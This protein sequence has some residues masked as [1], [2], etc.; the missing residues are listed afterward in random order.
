MNFPESEFHHRFE[1]L[2]QELERIN[3]DA[4]LITSEANFNYFTGYIAA[5]PWVS[6]SRNLL[7]ILPRQGQPVLVIPE[8]LSAEARHE[9]WIQQVYPST[10]VGEAPVATIASALRDLG[11]H[12]ARIG[13]E[14]GHEQRLGL[15][16][17]D[18][19]R[20]QSAIP[21]A[22][23]VDAS[24]AIW[25]LRMRKSAA[26]VDC[27]RESCRVTDS[28]F[29][30]L[31]PALRPGMTERDIARLMG[32]LL[33]E[34]GADRVGWIMMTSGRGQYHRTFGTP[35]D[36]VPQHGDMVWLDVSAIVN[37]YGA[38]YE[39]AGIIGGATSEQ[40][41]LQL[42][43]HEATMAGIDVIQPGLP[44]R[45]V[46]ETVSQRLERAGLQRLDAGRLGH[47][48]G[49]NSSEPPDVSLTDPTILAPGMVFTVEP[50]IVRDDG[51]YQIEQNVVVTDTGHEILSR[52]PHELRT[53]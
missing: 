23:F 38:D 30:R 5:H 4:L 35:R 43:V 20:L 14:L 53:I 50:A 33:L 48:L 44:V 10:E 1:L 24:D 49:L 42:A 19:Q 7:A 15:S 27:L 41:E 40:Q 13:A 31:F 37:G 11:L 32:Q 47:G 26:E 3:A 46:V 45:S 6:Y 51:I 39:R 22:Q 28:A 9:S 18:F 12:N 17:R 2:R 16:I 36:Y 8:F 34:E 29:E 25:A 52:S 21:A